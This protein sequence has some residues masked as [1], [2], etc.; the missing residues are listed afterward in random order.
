MVASTAT[1][2]CPSNAH[3]RKH[4]SYYLKSAANAYT[5]SVAGRISAS[6]MPATAKRRRS[7]CFHDTEWTIDAD[8]RPVAKRVYNVR[9]L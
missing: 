5:D 8:P 9:K 7:E 2:G 3:L 4:G 1:G 6:E